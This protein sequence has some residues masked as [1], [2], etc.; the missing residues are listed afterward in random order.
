LMREVG[1]S[2]ILAYE[3]TIDHVVG[4]LHARD[5]LRLAEPSESSL[6]IPDL[7]RPALFVPEGKRLDD[8]LREFQKGRAHMAVVVETT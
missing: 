4:I 6:G 1:H 7:L 3:G 2:R 8:L 5:L